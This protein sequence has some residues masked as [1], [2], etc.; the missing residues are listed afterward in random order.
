MELSDAYRPEVHLTIT[1]HT[2]VAEQHHYSMLMLQP[3]EGHIGAVCLQWPRLQEQHCHAP[4]QKL[5]QEQQQELQRHE[6]PNWM[7]ADRAPMLSSSCDSSSS[8]RHL[9]GSGSQWSSSDGQHGM[10]FAKESEAMSSSRSWD[11]IGHG[12][13]QD[14]LLHQHQSSLDVGRNDKLVSSVEPWELRMFECVPLGDVREIPPHK[15]QLLGST[16]KHV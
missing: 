5:K 11:E 10:D 13:N 7:S 9:S 14:A 12:E 2:D 1:S 6:G 3:C 16:C 8:Y 4:Q 15:W